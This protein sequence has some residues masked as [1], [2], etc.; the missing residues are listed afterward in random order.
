MHQSCIGAEPLSPVYDSVVEQREGRE[1]LVREA[2][3][4]YCACKTA[5]KQLTVEK[6]LYGFRFDLLE[7][8]VRSIVA[9]NY[10]HQ[11]HLSNRPVVQVAFNVSP[12]TIT[13]RPPSV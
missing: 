8:A 10:S 13:I 1:R 6:E 7:Q 5:L 12:S 2:V 3:E 11:L 4:D 9:Q